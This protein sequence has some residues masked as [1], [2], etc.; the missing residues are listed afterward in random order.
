M[1]S[2]LTPYRH[3]R[4]ALSR[5]HHTLTAHAALQPALQEAFSAMGVQLTA[6]GEVPAAWRG[7]VFDQAIR[8]GVLQEHRFHLR[9]APDHRDALVLAAA[10]RSTFRL[11]NIRAVI[12]QTGVSVVDGLRGQ[13]FDLIDTG[14]ARSAKP[15]WTVAGWVLVLPELMMS[16]GGLVAVPAAGLSAIAASLKAGRLPADPAAVQAQSP[17]EER[18]RAREIFRCLATRSPV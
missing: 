9:V 2:R 18:R 6:S 4:A 17:D 8:A 3:Y 15:G 16:T 10:E 1:D 5:L 11:L 12:P 14:L 13:A 7:A